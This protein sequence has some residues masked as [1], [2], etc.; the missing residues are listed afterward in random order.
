MNLD[1]IKEKAIKLLNKAMLTETAKPNT[2][3]LN[4]GATPEER[5]ASIREMAFASCFKK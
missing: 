5:T 4:L 1:K 2:Q 3:H